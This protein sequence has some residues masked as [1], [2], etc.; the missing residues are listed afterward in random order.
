MLQKFLFMF[1]LCAS[2][3]SPAAVW[4]PLKEWNQ[5]EERS[6]SRWIEQE[7]HKDFFVTGEFEGTGID[8]ADL[9]YASRLIYSYKFKLPFIISD[10]TST[11]RTI[12]QQSSLFD[13]LPP[14]ERFSEFLK[15]VLQ[16]TST[17]TLTA[18][19][20]P[21]AMNRS[22]LIPG[23][24]F[25]QRRNPMG[26]AQLIKRIDD[27]GN[28]HYLE[29]TV[30]PKSRT[31]MESSTQTVKPESTASGFRRWTWPQERKLTAK[32][33]TGFS[34]EQYENLGRSDQKSFRQWWKIQKAKLATTLESTESQASRGTQDLC[35][36]MQF[37]AQ[38]IINAMEYKNKVR[39][40]L[41]EAETDWFS[42]PGRDRRIIRTLENTLSLLTT[43]ERLGVQHI[44][45]LEQDFAAQC[46]QIQINSEETVTPLFF[47]K[48]LVLG[49]ASSDPNDNT[50]ERWGLQT[51]NGSPCPGY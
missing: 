25:L 6:F 46:S 31:L 3:P 12:S 38:V 13:H 40:C 9:I 8:C 47:L 34:L 26:H 4:I 1:F 33:R 35:T 17:H 5:D 22:F 36:L 48:K 15:Y 37:R 10:P 49:Q 30:P 24:F 7:F 11:S 21:V 2:L 43:E 16:I 41:T 19:S 45:L 20:D 27:Y 51:P 18:D 39:R 32:Q 28:V 50:R 42:S 23:A 44:D 14:S 29:S